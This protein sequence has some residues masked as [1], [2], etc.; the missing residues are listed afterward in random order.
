MASS[1][2]SNGASSGGLRSCPSTLV[3]NGGKSVRNVGDFVV[4]LNVDIFLFTTFCLKIISG[5]GRMWG[6][7]YSESSRRPWRRAWRVGG[8]SL[9]RRWSMAGSRDG[10]GE[11]HFGGRGKIAGESSA[12][13]CLT[14]ESGITLEELST[15]E[16]RIRSESMNASTGGSFLSVGIETGENS[17]GRSSSVDALARAGA[18]AGPET[19]GPAGRFGAA[20]EI[21]T[22]TE[23]GPEHLTLAGN[24]RAAPGISALERRFVAF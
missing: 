7:K 18:G 1:H 17:V 6:E 2:F 20:A 24:C 3:I 22:G 21:L 10:A 15:E 19:I 14:E 8:L 11:E 9:R 13:V 5:A 16:D 12:V 23:T 4:A